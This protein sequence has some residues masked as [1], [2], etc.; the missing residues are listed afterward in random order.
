M[1]LH[2]VLKKLLN[3]EPRTRNQFS[4]LVEEAAEDDEIDGFEGSGAFDEYEDEEIEQQEVNEIQ[5]EEVEEDSEIVADL[6]DVLPSAQPSV[7]QLTA[8][9]RKE[10]LAAAVNQGM[11]EDRDRSMDLIDEEVVPNR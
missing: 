10:R 9:L 5:Q 2:Q 6:D 4:I 7:A 8:D 1:N 3:S 11:F